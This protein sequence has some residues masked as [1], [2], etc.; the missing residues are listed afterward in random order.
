MFYSQKTYPGLEEFD[1][2]LGETIIGK[3]LIPNQDWEE[4]KAKFPSQ[5]NRVREN[6]ENYS[7]EL[8]RHAENIRHQVIIENEEAL[9]RE[10]ERENEKY[11]KEVVF[12][13]VEKLLATDL[14]ALS[15]EQL[16]KTNHTWVKW[17][18]Q[19]IYND[20]DFIKISDYYRDHYRVMAF[21]PMRERFN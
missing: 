14:A 3:G 1:N 19:V 10:I 15:P 13:A 7:Q 16:L 21:Q 17:H 18:Q 12:P 2:G 8:R 6:S 5:E 11:V 20:Y 9:R 4:W